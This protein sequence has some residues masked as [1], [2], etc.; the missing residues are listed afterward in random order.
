MPGTVSREIPL[1]HLAGGPEARLTGVSARTFW[2][3]A[4]LAQ[5]LVARALVRGQPGAWLG[6][7]DRAQWLSAGTAPEHRSTLGGHRPSPEEDPDLWGQT[8]GCP[9]LAW[10]VTGC[11]HPG[12]PASLSLVSLVWEGTGWVLSEGDLLVVAFR[13]HCVLSGSGGC[14]HRGSSRVPHREG[15]WEGPRLHFWGGDGLLLRGWRGRDPSPNLD[16]EGLGWSEAWSED[17]VL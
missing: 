10:L 2:R 4:K 9:A 16:H 11:S 13:G 14:F 6:S 12:S 1:S 3:W 15:R 7:G 8:Q 5:D 17:L